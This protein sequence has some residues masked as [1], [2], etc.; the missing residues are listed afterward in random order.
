MLILSISAA[1]VFVYERLLPRFLF[2]FHSVILLFSK[3]IRRTSYLS[4]GIPHTK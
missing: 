1:Y 3:T 2:I 4:I